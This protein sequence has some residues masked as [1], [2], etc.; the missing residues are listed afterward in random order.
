[1]CK[2]PCRPFTLIA[3]PTPLPRSPHQSQHYARRRLPNDKETAGH[4]Y[5]CGPRT[6]VLTTGLAA[7]LRSETRLADVV[8]L[9]CHHPE[10]PVLPGS[11]RLP[12]GYRVFWETDTGEAMKRSTKTAKFKAPKKKLVVRK[13]KMPVSFKSADWYGKAVRSFSLTNGEGAVHRELTAEQL[14]RGSRTT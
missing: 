14:E 5:R 1:M 7:R 12:V 11:L 10:P 8:A 6:R 4:R 3:T 9:P 13:I 2:H